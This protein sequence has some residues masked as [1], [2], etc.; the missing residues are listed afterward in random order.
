MSSPVPVCHQSQHATGAD[1]PVRDPGYDYD[2]HDKQMEH[3]LKIDVSSGEPTVLEQSLGD[4]VAG[5]DQ[6]LNEHADQFDP[7]RWADTDVRFLRRKAFAEVGMYLHHATYS[8]SPPPARIRSLVL[9]RV[10]S[11]D[12][13][14][15]VAR[16][17][18]KVT[19]YGYPI[20]FADDVGELSERTKA[21]FERTVARSD[22]WASERLPFRKLD[23]LHVCRLCGCETPVDVTHEEMIQRTC[24]AHEIN[25]GSVSVANTY[26]L[27]HVVMYH[28]NFGSGHCRFE[29]QPIPYRY[30]ASLHGLLLRFIAEEDCD[31]VGELLLS[32]ALERCLPRGLARFALNWYLDQVSPDGYVPCPGDSVP[33]G[34]QRGKFG[35]ESL[36]IDMGSWDERS[37]SWAKHY[38]PTLVGTTLG[39]VLL[40]RWP[41]ID[42]RARERSLDYEA[43]AS[44]LIDLG[45]VF[46][47]FADYK[48]QDGA[49]ILETVAGSATAEAYADVVALARE[50]LEWQRRPDGDYG[51]WTDEQAVFLASDPDHTP[52]QFQGQLLAPVIEQCERAITRLDGTG[53]NTAE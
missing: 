28:Q 15:L 24:A 20:A 6:W 18:D 34:A 14:H 43:E 41:E 52:S 29:D 11:E 26:A 32:A 10:N 2:A 23:L 3:N 27:T 44:T 7:L 51:Y 39:R 25:P 17:P 21:V 46:A 16:S 12:L 31:L 9:N 8:D 19:M 40:D 53:T 36:D 22:L 35:G 38:H 50:F 37:E 1:V 5:A 45:R 49:R 33:L 47:L 48:L 42:Y 4:L 30:P 13:R